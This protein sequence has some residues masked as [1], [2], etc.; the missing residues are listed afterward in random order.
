LKNWRRK[1]KKSKDFKKSKIK[2]VEEWRS[3]RIE[4]V[5]DLKFGDS[6]WVCDSSRVSEAT[7][8]CMPFGYPRISILGLAH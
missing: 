2:E 1:F 7:D 5:K 4:E 8:M 3:K 6:T